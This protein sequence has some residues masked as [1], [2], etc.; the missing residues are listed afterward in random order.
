MEKF[1]QKIIN[2]KIDLSRAKYSSSPE[3]EVVYES[4]GLIVFSQ[5]FCEA[6]DPDCSSWEDIE[7]KYHKTG[8]CA[9]IG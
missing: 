9:T 2:K 1:V 7:N 8:K 6:I 4:K 3:L 5:E